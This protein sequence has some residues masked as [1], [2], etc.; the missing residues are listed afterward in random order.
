MSKSSRTQRR[1]QKAFKGQRKLTSFGFMDPQYDPH[2]QLPIDPGPSPLTLLQ[3]SRKRSA[4][5]LSD[6]STDCDP[7]SEGEVLD[8]GQ[9]G[10]SVDRMDC[11]REK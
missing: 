10:V 8:D 2:L 9:A 5:V 7:H 6:P 4:S 11:T 1:Y 3:G